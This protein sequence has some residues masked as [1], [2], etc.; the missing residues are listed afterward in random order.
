MLW[1]MYFDMVFNTPKFPDHSKAIPDRGDT[2]LEEK[3]FVNRLNPQN[4]FRG[5]LVCPG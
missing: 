4:I 3:T 2:G 1:I 5:R